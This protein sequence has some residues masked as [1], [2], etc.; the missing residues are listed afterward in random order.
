[1]NSGRPLLLGNVRTQLKN[2]MDQRR[3]LYRDVARFTIET[4]DLDATQVADQAITLIEEDAMTTRLTVR[5]DHPYDVVIGNGVHEELR[6]LIGFG[7]GVL[8]VA[9]IHATGDARAGRAAAQAAGRRLARRAPDRGARQR[10]GQ[11]G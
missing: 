6:G 2:L 3:V 1:M 7:L 5:T 4:D 11:D 10:A 8:R 9:I